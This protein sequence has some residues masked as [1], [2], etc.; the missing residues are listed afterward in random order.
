MADVR[1]EEFPQVAAILHPAGYLA[2]D[3]GAR[4]V[5]ETKRLLAEGCPLVILSLEECPLINSLGMARLIEILEV[6]AEAGRM[7]WFADLSKL[8][9]Q[10]LAGAGVL[11]IIPKVTT[12]AEAKRALGL[13]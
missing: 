10:T 1:I 3:L 8:H 2:A 13:P 7:V 4:L 6:A 9:Q 5:G 12:V 11:P